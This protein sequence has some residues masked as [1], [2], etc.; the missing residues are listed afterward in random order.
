[1]LTSDKYQEGLNTLEKSKY[2]INYCKMPMFDIVCAGLANT[3][4]NHEYSEELTEE[5]K[6]LLNKLIN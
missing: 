4:L 6:Q 3:L 5:Q 2:N 1:M